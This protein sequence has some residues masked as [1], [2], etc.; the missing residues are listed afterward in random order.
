MKGKILD[1]N[2]QTGEGIISGNDSVRYNFSAAEWKSDKSPI[3][4]QIVDFSINEGDATGI[5][6]DKNVASVGGKSKIV[7]ALL[8]FFLGGLGIHKF[9][10]GCNTAGIIMLVLF[11]AGF[12]LVGIPTIII[13]IIA[14]IEFIMYLIKS[15][16]DFHQIYVENKKCWF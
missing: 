8:A 7:A 12:I 4:N 1:F 5:Y 10:L 2:I 6:L 16:E 11:L 9:Y 15:D 14:F 13:G 3:A